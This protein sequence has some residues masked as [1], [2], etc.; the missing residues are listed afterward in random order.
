MKE[1]LTFQE[2]LEKMKESPE[3]IIIGLILVFLSSIITIY[4]GGIILKNYYY[5]IF[6][7]KNLA[8]KK[9]Q[10]LSAGVDIGYFKDILKNPVFINKTK[11]KNVEY[12]FIDPLFYIQTIT[13]ENEQ[14]LAY[15]ITTR[16]KDFNPVLELGPYESAKGSLSIVL[17]KSKF[18]ELNYLGEPQKIKSYVGAHDLFYGEEYYFGNPGN[19]QSY[20]FSLNEAGYCGIE[21]KNCNNS[22]FPPMN[23]IDKEIKISN[24]QIQDFRKGGIIN[25]YTVT[26]PLTSLEIIF[27]DPDSPMPYGVNY[28]QVR[29]LK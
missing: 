20:A 14:V 18:E 1:K 8:L 9:I 29:I 15:S 12:I 4:E 3:I 2:L 6:G 16:K 17:G 22:I 23:I 7:Q 26:A 13:D 28:N 27:C 25:T 19:Y 11:C 24:K 10:K 5:D 21:N